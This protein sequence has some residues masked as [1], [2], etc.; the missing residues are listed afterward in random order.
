MYVNF[1]ILRVANSIVTPTG[2]QLDIISFL[3]SSFQCSSSFSL[4]ATMKKKKSPKSTP[5]PDMLPEYDFSNGE[6]GR[7]AK[8]FAKGV[9]ITVLKPA[10]TKSK[11]KKA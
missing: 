4:L 9:T 1:D 7:Y 8:H 3:S 2:A 6:R 5:E 11:K 10:V